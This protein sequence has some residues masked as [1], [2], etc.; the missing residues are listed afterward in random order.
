MVEQAALVR[1]ALFPVHLS[2]MAVEAAERL[3]IHIMGV[4]AVPV[5]AAMVAETELRPLRDLRIPAEAE[6]EVIGIPGQPQAALVLL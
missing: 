5:A 6:A 2:R 4:Q 1:Q 3:I